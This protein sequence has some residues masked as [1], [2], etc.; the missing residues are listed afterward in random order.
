MEGSDV[1]SLV[2]LC[3]FL[4]VIFNEYDNLLVLWI[5]RLMNGFFVGLQVSF[6]VVEII[7]FG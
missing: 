5:K 1:V 4:S 3:Q 6:L 2:M 7:R